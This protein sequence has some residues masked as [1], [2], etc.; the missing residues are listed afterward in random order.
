VTL[1][2]DEN[3]DA[4]GRLVTVRTT[5]EADVA[6]AQVRATHLRRMPRRPQEAEPGTALP[7]RRLESPARHRRWVM[8][9]KHPAASPL[10]DYVVVRDE[11]AAAEPAAFHLFVL[12][13]QV[14]RQGRTFRFDGQLDA[15][16]VLYLATPEP[17][18]V[19]VAEWGW[20]RGDPNA[21][22]G[23]REAEVPPDFDPVRGTW[24]LGEVQQGVHVQARPGQPFLAVLYAYP[25]GT[26]APTF[27]AVADGRGVRVTLGPASETVYLASDPP[28]EAG[29]QASVH[30]GG[31]RTVVIERA[32]EP[33]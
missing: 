3:M 22:D 32:V 6:V 30:R 15:D 19:T 25:K 21:R 27:E 17:E 28:T 26:P 2:E 14:R 20:L 16:A 31:Q 33:L 11:L 9:V 10:A 13:R 24:R 4:G 8:L 18:T 23:G 12:A 7:R 29:G 1:G 5:P